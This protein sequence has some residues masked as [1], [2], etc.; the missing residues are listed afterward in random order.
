MLKDQPPI[1]DF[2]TYL[3]SLMYESDSRFCVSQRL[4]CVTFGSARSNTGGGGGQPQKNPK[5]TKKRKP[6]MGTAGNIIGIFWS[7]SCHIQSIVPGL[8]Y[9]GCMRALDMINSSKQL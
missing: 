3:I 2:L 7:H 6:K 8:I 1:I 9:N 4:I 5:K